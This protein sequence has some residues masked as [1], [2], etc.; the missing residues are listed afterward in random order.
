MQ[1]LFVLDLHGHIKEYK[2][3]YEYSNE[4]K[5]NAILFGGD[6]LPM[7]PKMSN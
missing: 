6:L 3:Y 5:P 2:R 4:Y 1:C 7:I